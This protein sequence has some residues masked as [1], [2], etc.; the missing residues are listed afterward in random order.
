MA[1]LMAKNCN[2]TVEQTIFLSEPSSTLFS[3]SSVRMIKGMT[4][5]KGGSKLP[6]ILGLV[7]GLVAA[8][9]VV[10]YL[11]SAKTKPP[12]PAVAVAAGVPVV[13]AASDVAAGTR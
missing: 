7:L 13:V 12:P 4:L 8:V 11:S 2:S 9:L 10:V 6:L 1:R 5:P 3:S